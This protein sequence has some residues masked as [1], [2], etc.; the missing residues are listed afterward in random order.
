MRHNSWCQQLL[1]L[2]DT[3]ATSSQEQPRTQMAWK[4]KCIRYV[5]IKR[6]EVDVPVVLHFIVQYEFVQ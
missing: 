2:P 6:E 1:Q 3:S 5:E 4:G